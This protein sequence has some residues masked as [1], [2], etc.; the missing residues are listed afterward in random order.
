MLVV[1]SAMVKSGA[2]ELC[3]TLCVKGLARNVPERRMTA[4]IAASVGRLDDGLHDERMFCL[5]SAVDL[6]VGQ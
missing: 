6:R 4:F 3:G 1:P 5:C 2:L